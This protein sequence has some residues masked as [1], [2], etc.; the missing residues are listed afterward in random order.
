MIEFKQII[1]RGTRTIEGKDFFTV[2]DFVKAHQNFEDSEWDGD[3]LPLDECKVCGDT[4]CSCEP[5]P[6]DDCGFRPCVCKKTCAKCQQDP[7]ACELETCA[8]CGSSPC[9]CEPEACAKCGNSPC[10]CNEKIVIKL[11]D[12]KTRQIRHIDAVMYWS[13]EGKPITGPDFLGRMFGDLPRFFKDEDQLREIW[14][15]PTT[16][17][18]L[19]ADLSDDGYDAEKLDAMKDL[20]E[21]RGSDVY[22]VLAYVAFSAE[23]QTRWDRVKH[24]NTEIRENFDY[25]QQEFI[26]FVLEKY[27]ADGVHELA[28][29][30]MKSLI[31]LK[32]NTINDATSEFGSPANIRNMFVG[33]Q[34]Y[35][36]E[37]REQR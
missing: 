14:S 23:T 19:L 17:E 6:C 25:K 36:Y 35:L 30:K 28:T 31:E 7:C 27:I 15:D 5:L 37:D 16:R 22:D 10:S 29:S 11:S 18:K 20:I 3:P 24:A 4:P 8:V 21:A 12:G 9:L 1:G 26:N 33:F 13:A 2:F 34:K 32:Y